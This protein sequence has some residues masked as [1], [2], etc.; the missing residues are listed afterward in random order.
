MK[1]II[2][3]INLLH[4][5][6]TLKQTKYNLYK[7]MEIKFA[8]SFG[9]SIKTLIR[10][11]TWWYKTYNLFRSD[12]PRFIKNIWKF[13][14]G[15]WNHYWFDHHGTM[16]MMEIGL[17]DIANT[18]EK[19][20]NEIDETRLKKVDAMRRV[21]QLIQNYNNDSYIEM[22]EKELGELVLRKWEFE[23]VPD[24]PG[25]SQLIDNET[26]NEKEHNGKVFYRAREIEK[27]EWEEL[28]VILKGQD[29]TKFDKDIDWNEQFDGSGLKNW[30]D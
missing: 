7:N 30:W 21:I 1:D 18:T 9:E 27:M 8:D 26:E 17:T 6:G 16:M 29:Y 28:F 24:K 20:G 11:N 10:H 23:N 13:R 4:L 12:I 19:Y 14:K 3:K 2:M 15:L 22:A 25:F 5:I